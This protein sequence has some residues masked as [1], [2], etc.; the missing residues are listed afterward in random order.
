MGRNGIPE[1]QSFSL[2]SDLLSVSNILPTDLITSGEEML[3]PKIMRSRMLCK[4]HVSAGSDSGGL[5]LLHVLKEVGHE[6]KETAKDVLDGD[7][8]EN[9]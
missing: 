6:L 2:K 8:D 1:G 4:V 5:E 9:R 3:G 7:R